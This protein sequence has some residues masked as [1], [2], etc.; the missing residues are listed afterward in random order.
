MQQTK[1][2]FVY[3]PFISFI[4]FHILMSSCRL[5]SQY[6]NL[7]S[8]LNRKMSCI[9]TSTIAGTDFICGK[10]WRAKVERNASVSTSYL[11]NTKK[12]KWL[13]IINTQ[14]HTLGW[15][16]KKCKQIQLLDNITKQFLSE[17][18]SIQIVTR[19]ISGWRIFFPGHVRIFKLVPCKVWHNIIDIPN[20]ELPSSSSPNSK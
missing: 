19:Y 5:S 16:Y 3:S 20:L 15:K 1:A 4:V 6:A 14:S 8:I 10:G 13:Q 12:I 17:I 9:N 2:T 18:W 11:A 7:S